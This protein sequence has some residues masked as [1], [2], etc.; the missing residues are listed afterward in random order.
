MLRHRNWLTSLAL[1]LAVLMVTPISQADQWNKK[2]IITINNSLQI[3]GATL[4]PGKY[5]MRLVDS[6]SNRHIVRVLSED[7]KEVIATILATPNYRLSPTGETELS[8]WEVPKGSPAALRAWFY[9]GDNFGQEFAYPK[10]QA[11]AL[12]ASL[13]AEV[14]AISDEDQAV[15]AEASNEPAAVQEEQRE[16]AT[17]PTVTAVA[18]PPAGEVEPAPAPPEPAVQEPAESRVEEGI[19]VEVPS[20]LPRTASSMPLIGLVGALLLGLGFMI[21][22]IRFLS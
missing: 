10:D 16:E 9:P 21:R 1:V 3:P 12:S 6:Q 7:E 18:E 20:A 17:P 8:F 13:A 22:V 11:T 19:A 14:P 4:Q 5:V 2:T 15:I